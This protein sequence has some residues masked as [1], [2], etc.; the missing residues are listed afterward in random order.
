VSLFRKQVFES[1]ADRLHGEVVL[2][3]PVSTRFLALALFF[4]LAIA[5]IWISRG[6]FARVETVRGIL[7]TN[8]AS[9]KVIAQQSG[10]VSEVAVAEGQ[11]V[12]QGERLVVIHS[13]RLTTD[14]GEVAS[15]SLSTIEARRQLSETQMALAAS[16]AAAERGR[17]SAA[18]ASAE[19]Q[20]ANLNAQIALQ[21]EVVASNQQIFDQIARVVDRGFVSK[22]EFERRRQTL[23]N[24]QLALAGFQQRRTASIA[25]AAQ[26]HSQLASVDIETAQ[27]IS[28]VRDSLEILSAEKARLQ[29]EHSYVVTAPIAG[30]VTAFA[31]GEG[32]P[33]NPGTPLMIIVPDKTKLWAELY[34]PSRAVGFVEPGKETRLLYDSFPYQRFGSFLG[35]VS[36]ISRIAVDPRDTE[37]P[38][39]FEEPVYR[40]RVDLVEQAVKAFGT[41]TPLQPGMTLRANIVLERQSFLAWLLQPLKAVLNQNG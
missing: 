27:G 38:F 2:S 33:I 3:Q 17:L 32:R 19:Q 11:L 41:A 30:R 36:S 25:E 14:G 23:L 37:I 34:A 10:T 22:V 21:E 8:V 13:D 35:K 28:Q 9:A 18:L 16:R 12:G 26:V 7:V 39:P 24:A 15:R 29:G 20:S 40:V 31:T 6:T 4:I 5:A 1:R